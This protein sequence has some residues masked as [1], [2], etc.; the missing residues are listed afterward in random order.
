MRSHVSPRELARAIG[1]SESSLKRW[2]DDGRLSVDRTAGGHRRIPLSEAVRFIRSAGVPLVHPELLPLPN[3]AEPAAVPP[4]DAAPAGEACERLQELL[5]ADDP[6]AARAYVH[7]LF[8]AGWPVY[9]ICDGP[10]R[11][12]LTWIGEMWKHDSSGV[13]FEHRATQTCI[14]ALA[15]LRPLLAPPQPDAPLALGCAP[16]GDPYLIPSRMAALVLAECGY[17]DQDLGPDT[18]LASLLA[19]IAHLRPA[20]IW[21]AM[22]VPAADPRATERD[23]GAIAEAAGRVGATLVIGG[24]GAPGLRLPDGAD[25]FRGASMAEL[26]AFARGRLAPARV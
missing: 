23:V 24:R 6:A 18:P 26:A 14:E 2:A 15:Q 1:V 22:S 10:I 13:F 21:L 12:A 11:N 5:L 4:P 19:A 3:P 9:L 8:M 16:S 7:S 25:V 17:R 20:L